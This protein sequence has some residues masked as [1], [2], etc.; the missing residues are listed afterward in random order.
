[1][2]TFVTI[3]LVLAA[4]NGA[5][6]LILG[7]LFS[8]LLPGGW[9][10]VAAVALLLLLPLFVLAR[11]FSG[12]V[13]PAALTR[14]WVYRPFWYGQLFLP[15]LAAAGLAG[16][17]AGL[18]FGAAQ[19]SGRWAVG[20]MGAVLVVA[21]VWGYVGT[22]RLVVRQLELSFRG[23]PPGLE[24]MRIVQLS[25]LHVGPHTSRRHLARIAA[26]VREA[27]AD[28][29]AVTGDQVDD[30]AR[31]VEPLGRALG[32]LAAPLGVIAV[33]GNH[34]VYAGWAPVRRGMER[35]GW[36][37][38]VNE[39]VPLERGGSRFWVA[40]TGDRAGRGGPTGPDASVVP[41]V[42]RTLARVPPG[43]FT[44]VLAHNP[45]LWPRLA[46]RGVDLTLSGHT[47]YGQLA[48]PR[49]GWSMASVFLD[50]AMGMY[51]SGDSVLYINPGTNFWG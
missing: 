46:A 23:L 8:P 36:R 20:L 39:A 6:W 9:R 50:L 18:P 30:Y 22:R 33:A 15:L 41:D 28:L 2:R 17:L 37:V 29:I 34:D 47:H 51:R 10:T 5:L 38:L 11:G 45:A 3:F 21:A 19:R 25:D 13:Y 24:G 48:L 31:D 26:A 43:A 40:G 12:G 4:W 32:G 1:M 44:V 7:G 35:L 49:L 14:V 27:R 42:E 16:L